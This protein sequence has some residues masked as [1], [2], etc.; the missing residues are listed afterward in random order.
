MLDQL[1]SEYSGEF[2]RMG[3]PNLVCS[4]LPHHWR[5]NKTLPS[6]FKV[7]AL[8][9][10]PDHQDGQRRKLLRRHTKPHSH[11]EGPSGQVQRF[12]ICW[13]LGQGQEFLSDDNRGNQPANCR[14]LSEGNQGD[15]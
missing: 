6:T 4:A 14:N 5:S 7:V 15:G 12:A 8:S 13:P 11:N 2:V 9:E 1:L 3:S 10:I